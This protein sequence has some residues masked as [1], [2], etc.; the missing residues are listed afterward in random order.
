M[1]SHY[2]PLSPQSNKLKKKIT[3]KTTPIVLIGAFKIASEKKIVGEVEYLFI[4]C[5]VHLYFFGELLFLVLFLF[6][7]CT[8]LFILLTSK[9]SL[10][11]RDLK[12][13]L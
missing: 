10:Y 11:I 3:H 7:Y 13:C 9:S 8:S 4:L 2:Q 1:F 5:F 12:L 6:F